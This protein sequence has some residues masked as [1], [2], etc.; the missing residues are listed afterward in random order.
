MTLY[1]ILP[2]KDREIINLGV[3]LAAGCQPCMK[4]HLR[5]CKETGLSEEEIHEILYLVG[6]IW[7]R[8]YGIMKGRV[9]TLNHAA[10]CTENGISS[11]GQSR[12]EILLGLAVSYTVNSTDLTEQ[13][14]ACAGE[15]KMNESEIAAIIDLAKFTWARARAHADIIF[16]RRGVLYQDGGKEGEN[17]GCG[18]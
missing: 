3:S 16:E 18:C 7:S 2:E 6:D 13:Y 14:L 9:L 15:S 4:Y 1:S 12:M 10:L 11:E 5:K 17:C 8:A